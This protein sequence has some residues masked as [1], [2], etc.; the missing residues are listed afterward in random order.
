MALLSKYNLKHSQQIF[1]N[2]HTVYWNKH[3]LP[4]IQ[5]LMTEIMKHEEFPH[6]D[7]HD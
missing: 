1:V 2:Q 6:D 5:G 4:A 3:T 7:N